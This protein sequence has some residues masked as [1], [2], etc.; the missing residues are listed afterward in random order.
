MALGS[1]VATSSLYMVKKSK[2]TIKAIKGYYYKEEL[3]INLDRIKQTLTD[4]NVCTS[5]FQT[6]S[7]GNGSFVPDINLSEQGLVLQRNVKFGNN[8]KFQIID[9]QFQEHS[10]P[11]QINLVLNIDIADDYYGAS[12][13]VQ[14]VNLY[15][16]KDGGGNITECF[17]D[18]VLPGQTQGLVELAVN[19][20]CQGPGATVSDGKCTIKSFKPDQLASIQ[21]PGAGKVV[22]AI[23]ELPNGQYQVHCEDNPY[24]LPSK[25]ADSCPED[26]AMELNETGEFSCRA[27]LI[28][29]ISTHL[30]Q[31][32]ASGCAQKLK[33]GHSSL[34]QTFCN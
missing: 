32:M 31:S 9:M 28:S 7:S 23:H 1:F 25:T 11:N 20:Y 17:H 10:N 2:D 24:Y 29:D 14:Q 6:L 26:F 5:A 4:I 27:L 16:E 13:I 22:Q 19:D 15:V 12:E 18:P 3:H 30:S 33:L 8:R 21:C 34:V